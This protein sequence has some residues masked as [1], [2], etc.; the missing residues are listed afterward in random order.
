MNSG[1]QHLSARASTVGGIA[2]VSHGTLR[3]TLDGSVSPCC[4]G[5]ETSTRSSGN[6]SS[7]DSIASKVQ[8]QTG[9]E[10]AVEVTCLARHVQHARLADGC[11]TACGGAETRCLSAEQGHRPEG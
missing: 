9:T 10:P 7:L 1:L 3:G 8:P 2:G 4:T 5:G 11:Q 6:G